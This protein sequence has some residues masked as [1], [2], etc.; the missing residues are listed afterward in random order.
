MFSVLSSVPLREQNLIGLSG[1][2]PVHLQTYTFI[3]MLYFF[4]NI[5]HFVQHLA[6]SLNSVSPASFY[7]G[8]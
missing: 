8:N 1:F 7:S 2:F 3:R 6:F 4:T 5:A